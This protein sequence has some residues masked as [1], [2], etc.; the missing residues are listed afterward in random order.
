MRLSDARQNGLALCRR[1]LPAL[2]ALGLLALLA[3]SAGAVERHVSTAGADRKTATWPNDCTVLADPCRTI[4]W[5]LGWA[6]QAPGDWIKVQTGTY[7]ENIDVL[8]G[9]SLVATVV[10]GGWGPDGSYTTDSAATV[11]DGSGGGY[12]SSTISIALVDNALDM[13]IRNFRVIGGNAERGGGL[14]VRTPNAG[15]ATLEV[16]DIEFDGNRAR[17]DGGA[18]YL[19]ARASSDRFTLR[20]SNNVFTNNVAWGTAAGGGPYGHGGALSVINHSHGLSLYLHDNTFRSNHASEEGGAIRIYAD[21]QGSA[22]SR[23]TVYVQ[24]WRNVLDANTTDFVAGGAIFRAAGVAYIDAYLAN[25]LIVANESGVSAITEGAAIIHLDL[26]NDTVAD[27]SGWGGVFTDTSASGGSIAVSLHNAVLWGNASRDLYIDYFGVATAEYSDIGSIATHP[28]GGSYTDGGGNISQDPA[29]LDPAGGNYRPRWDSPLVDSATCDA[30]TNHQDFE[31]DPRPD[32]VTGLCD[33]GFDEVAPAVLNNGEAP[34]NPDNV[35]DDDRYAANSGLDVFNRWCAI[36]VVC[37]GTRPATV[38]EVVAGADIGNRIRIYQTSVVRLRGGAIG[39][40]EIFAFD[41]SLVEIAGSGF[42]VEG[43]PVPHG[44]LTGRKGRLTGVLESGEPLDVL[45][46]QGGAAGGKYSGTVRLIPPSNLYLLN[47]GSRHTISDYLHQDDVVHMFDG[48]CLLPGGC[49]SVTTR[50][51]LDAGQTQEMQLFDTSELFMNGGYVYGSVL[52]SDRAR[53]SLVGG[54][55]REN[56]AAF[57]NAS[58]MLGGSGEGTHVAGGIFAFDTSDVTVTWGN[59]YGDLSAFDSATIAI[60][61]DWAGGSRALS[62]RNS[63]VIEVYGYDFRVGSVPVAYGD[64]VASSGTLTGELVTSG[65]FA[66]D[67]QRSGGVIRLLEGQTSWLNSGGVMTVD[68]DSYQFQ[69]VYVRNQG[70]VGDSLTPCASP[71]ATDVQLGSAAV[72]GS[73]LEV[74]DDSTVAF[75]GSTLGGRLR[76]FGTS[77][78][79]MTG[80]LIHGQ[81]VPYDASSFSMDGG[82][83]LRLYSTGTSTSSLNAGSVARGVYVDQSSS[84]ILDGATVSFDGVEVH[85]AGSMTMSAGQIQGDLN[86]ASSSSLLLSGGQLGRNLFVRSGTATITGG[87]IT[88]N[89]EVGNFSFQRVRVELSGGEVGRS[90]EI[91]GAA[92]VTVAGGVIREGVTVGGAS[93]LVV[94][95]GEIHGSGILADEQSQV[96][97]NGGAIDGRLAALGT[98][99]IELRGGTLGGLDPFPPQP[100]GLYAADSTTIRVYGSDFT[101]DGVP[102]PLGLLAATSGTLAGTLASAEPVSVAF[103]QGQASGFTGTIEL[104]PEPGLALLQFSSLLGLFALRRLR[105]GR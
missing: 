55:I 25:N 97:V 37:P 3:G 32:L 89:L 92:D 79:A 81:V 53:L 71:V 11:I 78:V 16:Y 40:G 63:S 59:S 64:V 24:M 6:A 82:L 75:D 30:V 88:E 38:V 51:N 105:V 28:N 7:V 86:F 12:P 54:S 50:L 99:S 69:R 47:D 43:L 34:P 74:F 95:A 18:V 84:L 85:A 35:I 98:A 103:Q 8:S 68:D 102:V 27:N 72:L 57:G 14:Y 67:F 39:S 13:T 36:G 61:G 19:A 56:L 44:D 101:V 70:C 29:F 80:G 2:S 90:L 49:R 31:R 91:T 9:W 77:R 58:V 1:A 22:L 10:E 21:D 23:D 48:P 33:M 26:E 94:D 83:I 45:L 42:A 96:E 62:A 5:A 87:S 4:Q 76:T 60:K 66:F 20:L 100:P 93:T 17:Y 52:A 104:V 46:H 41:S 73:R 15:T 65:G